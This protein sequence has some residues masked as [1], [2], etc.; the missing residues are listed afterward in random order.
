[1][2]GLGALLANRVAG[3]LS[4]RLGAAAD[5]VDIPRLLQGSGRVPAADL[6]GTRDALA[7]ALSSVFLATGLLA[8][9]GVVIAI[10]LEERPL[11][12]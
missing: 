4:D 11:R 6:D 10:A 9:A 1:V 5:R 3:E 12:T 7:H 2:A 8:V